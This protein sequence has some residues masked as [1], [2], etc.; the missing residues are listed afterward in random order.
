MRSLKGLIIGLLIFVAAVAYAWQAGDRV[1]GQWSDG[2]W[3]PAS[4]AGV[5]GANYSVS[6]DDGDTAVLPAS[7]V[8]AMNWKVGTKV[9]CNW[10]QGGVYYSGTI[11]S[12]EGEYIHISYDDGDQEDSTI[13]ICRSK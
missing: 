10:K 7:K 11:T 3:Y 9:Q 12:M 6:F 1:L 5:D 8:R 4:I 2:Y 13:S